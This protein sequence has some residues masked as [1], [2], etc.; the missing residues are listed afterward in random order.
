MKEKGLFFLCAIAYRTGHLR[1][2]RRS[3]TLASRTRCQRR[4][5]ARNPP[6]RMCSSFFSSFSLSAKRREERRTRPAPLYGGRLCA[7]PLWVSVTPFLK[8]KLGMGLRRVTHSTVAERAIASALV[9]PS[10]YRPPPLR[11]PTPP[12][13][14]LPTRPPQPDHPD[15]PIFGA[16]GPPQ[17]SPDPPQIGPTP[18]GIISTTLTL[19]GPP[20][21]PIS[22]RFS[23]GK[24]GFSKNGGFFRH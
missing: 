17:K 2:P 5:R 12:I 8:P 13:P 11:S 4:Y 14:T 20:E 19:L 24:S 1:H 22:S 3:A 7:L 18:P 21:N 10:D 6:V 9:W 23:R 15:P 16:P